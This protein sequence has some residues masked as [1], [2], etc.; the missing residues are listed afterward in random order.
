MFDG[1]LV[2]TEKVALILKDGHINK[3]IVFE[4][5]YELEEVLHINCL[6]FDNIDCKSLSIDTESLAL[7]IRVTN[8]QALACAR[9]QIK[10]E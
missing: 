3:I 5:N 1:L 10:Q 9:Y 2:Q 6:P 4:C 7:S 8:Y